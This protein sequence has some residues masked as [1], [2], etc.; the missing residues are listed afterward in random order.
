MKTIKK[1][2]I[3][4]PNKIPYK[5]RQK[6]AINKSNQKVQWIPRNFANRPNF[7]QIWKPKFNELSPK[8]RIDYETWKRERIT[9]TRPW[10]LTDK[11]WDLKF[12]LTFGGKLKMTIHRILL[13]ESF[14][15]S[16]EKNLDS[17]PSFLFRQSKNYIIVKI[18]RKILKWKTWI[19]SFLSKALREKHFDKSW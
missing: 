14:G 2:P 11:F 1:I 3:K 18:F 15:K 5:F 7:E 10:T 19:F 4:V 8:F 12:E 17:W 9:R 6:L 13:P 16:T